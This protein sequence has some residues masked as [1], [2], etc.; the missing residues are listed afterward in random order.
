MCITAIGSDTLG[1]FPVPGL[2]LD[3]N[4]NW[5][6]EWAILVG[7]WKTVVQGA[8]QIMMALL[9]NS[10]LKPLPKAFQLHSQLVTAMAPLLG[11]NCWMTYFFSLLC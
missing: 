6:K 7:G 10:H 2:L 9:P 3:L 8:M 1:H 5:M 4:I 11:T